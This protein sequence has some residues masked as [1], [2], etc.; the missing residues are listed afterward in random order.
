MPTAGSPGSLEGCGPE[1][2]EVQRFLDVNLAPAVLRVLASLEHLLVS[3]AHR[4]DQTMWVALDAALR[5]AKRTRVKWGGVQLVM[6]GDFLQ[7][8]DGIPLFAQ[9]DFNDSFK[10]ICLPTQYRSNGALDSLL[11]ALSMR[12]EVDALPLEIVGQLSSL[13]RPLQ[14]ELS[15]VAV[16]LFGK[17]ESTKAYNVQE[18]GKLP[19]DPVLYRGVDIADDNAASAALDRSTNLSAEPLPLKLQSRVMLLTNELSRKYPGLCSGALGEVVK[20]PELPEVQLLHSGFPL[21]SPDFAPSVLFRLR[22]GAII[23]VPIP[24]ITRE[25]G[26]S[27]RT[28]LPLALA[29]G[30][31]V[32][33]AAGLTLPAAVLHADTLWPLGGLAYTGL[34]RV[35]SMDHV[36]ITGSLRLN[37]VFSREDCVDFLRGQLAAISL[38]DA[39]QS[40]Y[41]AIS[42]RLQGACR[43][44]RQNASVQPGVHATMREAASAGGDGGGGD[45]GGEG[46]GGEGGG[47]GRGGE[48]GGGEGGG[49]GGGEGGGG[50]GGGE[51][52]GGEG[53]GDGGG[54]E[55]GGDAAMREAASAGAAQADAEFADLLG[56]SR[57]LR[58]AAQAL[59]NG[60][61]TAERRAEVKQ[62]ADDDLLLGL[63]GHIRMDTGVYT[64]GSQAGAQRRNA[65]WAR[66]VCRR[67]LTA[68]P[69]QPLDA[70]HTLDASTGLDAVRAPY[71]A[72]S[73]RLQGAKRLR[74][75]VEPRVHEPMGAKPYEEL[76]DKTV[77]PFGISQPRCRAPCQRRRQGH[78]AAM[79]GAFLTAERDGR[80]IRAGRT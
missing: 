45:G 39:V 43:F 44:K 17:L 67:P 34:S 57:D 18:N 11:R 60:E 75:S 79:P 22:S 37:Y 35:R 16:H 24:A 52:G 42:V 53:G 26:G 74:A 3:E 31:T 47:E 56:F 40:P 49:S 61:A 54:G 29:F 63:N 23:T 6:E 7:L 38:G 68:R 62:R 36:Q 12:K 2:Q 14:R 25:S 76:P 10:V 65:A 73:I 77:S 59:G 5:R 64:D 69:T 21:D 19:G 41:A 70:E 78:L 55:G 48:G 51:G 32:H 66:V 4:I 58:S 15:D 13:K 30:L 9:A 1:S 46:G 33:R 80:A 28:A 71:A 8:T 50:E 27:S 20:L 72:I